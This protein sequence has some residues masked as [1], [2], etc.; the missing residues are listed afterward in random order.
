MKNP[1]GTWTDYAIREVW[2]KG[3]DVDRRNPDEGK[4]DQA[5]GKILFSEYGNRESDFG[6]EIDHIFPEAKL[7][8]AGVPQELIDHIDNLRPMNW[9]NNIRK[10]DE[11]PDYPGKVVFAGKD[12]LIVERDY[13]VRYEIV[14]KL[15]ELYKG[16]IEINLPDTLD[17]WLSEIAEESSN[18]NGKNNT[19]FD[20]IK[21]ISIHDLD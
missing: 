7:R 8:S 2:N 21:T 17:K 11:F 10:S 13:R 19:Y 14:R 3:L 6:W 1:D 15:K 18:I 20:E 5:H 12:N 16:Y 9:Q 4:L